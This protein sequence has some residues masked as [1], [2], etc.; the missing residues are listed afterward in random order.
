M[1]NKLESKP[2]KSIEELIKIINSRGII[3]GD[4]DKVKEILTRISYQRLMAYRINFLEDETENKYFKGTSIEKIYTMYKFDRDI[5]FILYEA[6]ESIEMM[7]RTMIAYNMG[8]K[9]GSHCYLDS[10][11]FIDKDYHKNFIKELNEK[12]DKKI[13]EYKKHLMVKHHYKNY[14]DELPIY[15]A[16]ELLTFGQTSKLFKNLKE[17]DKNE[18]INKFKRK[19]HKLKSENFTSWLITLTE[20]RNICAH[21]DILWNRRFEIKFLKNKDWKD[22][23]CFITKEG[24]QVYSIFGVLLIF[25]T[26]LLDEEIY[27]SCIVSLLEL[28]NTNAEIISKNKIGFPEN[29]ETILS[30]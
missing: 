5:K 12:I 7:L 9:Y 29:W 24:K 30:R 4:E 17:E 23:I 14:S 6:I 18:I 28:I 13:P 25:K 2:M 15:K 22:S 27:N 26:I 11:V 10:K 8:L 19:E 16:I 1:E 21:H 3:I 20:I